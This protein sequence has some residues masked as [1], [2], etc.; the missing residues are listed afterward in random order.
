[1]NSTSHHK[2]SFWSFLFYC[3][4]FFTG[5][6][7]L[8]EGLARL[9]FIQNFIP[10]RSVDNFDYQFEIK[11]FRLQDYVKQNGGVDIL[12]VG[13]SLVNTGIDPQVVGK[14]YA[15]QTGV[16]PRM[17]NFGVEGMTISPN[18]AIAHILVELYH[19]ALIVYI[20]DMPDYIAGNG[21]DYEN[22]LLADP[23][24]HYMNGQNDPFGWLLDHS[25]GLQ[26]YLPFR[27]WM[28][29]D[30]LD[31]VSL[32]IKRYYD[33]TAS[34]YEADSLI[35]SGIDI[36]P[37]P[38]NPEDA[39]YF[40]DFGNYQ[41]APSRL[42]NLKNL[43]TYSR[44][45]GTTVLVVEM[46]V[47]PTFYDFIGGLAVHKQFQQTLSSLVTDNGGTFLPAEACLNLIPLNGRSNRWHLN[48]IGAPIFSQCL[49]DQLAAF[50]RQ[51]NTTFV[52]PVDSK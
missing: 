2:T 21:L 40:Q 14:A 30:F 44:S 31:T 50:A 10:Y 11:W 5:A 22:R 47:H 48:Y 32:Y 37:N 39:Q 26:H 7:I 25:A 20:T 51:Q 49:G 36:P 18:S 43:I 33:T 13:S 1:M 9:P 42:D 6:A 45:Q 19:P 27:N 35:G 3:L 29:A 23:W 38:S 34:G 8:L 52:K 46:P 28:H 24:F 12:F 16:Q 4:L 17:F 41:I 15:A